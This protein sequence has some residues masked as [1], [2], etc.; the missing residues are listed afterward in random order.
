MS[1]DGIESSKSSSEGIRRKR[2]WLSFPQ[3]VRSVMYAMF[4]TGLGY[5]AGTK[6]TNSSTLYMTL[7]CFIVLLDVLMSAYLT[8]R[9]R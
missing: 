5:I 2:L 3:A 9:E 1:S 4:C 6:D 8:S 7:L